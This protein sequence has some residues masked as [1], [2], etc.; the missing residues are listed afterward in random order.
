LNGNTLLCQQS[1]E[2]YP[3]ISQTQ[4][5]VY[6]QLPVNTFGSQSHVPLNQTL[7]P[8]QSGTLVYTR[9]NSSFVPYNQS[10]V[11]SGNNALTVVTNGNQAISQPANRQIVLQPEN[12]QVI[13]QPAN[14]QTISQPAI[15]QTI[16][17]PT[18]QQ[19]QVAANGHSSFPVDN[20][21]QHS[22]NSAF[23]TVSKPDENSAFNSPNV[24]TPASKHR[25]SQ[26]TVVYPGC[27]NFVKQRVPLSKGSHPGVTETVTSVPKIIRAPGRLKCQTSSASSTRQLT[28]PTLGRDTSGTST[29]ALTVN[30]TTGPKSNETPPHVVSSV[31]QQSVNCVSQGS[32]K[33]IQVHTISDPSM[34]FKLLEQTSGVETQNPTG[35]TKSSLTSTTFIGDSGNTRTNSVITSD[36]G[37]I[38][39]PENSLPVIQVSNI[40]TNT[41]NGLNQSSNPP[42]YTYIFNPSVPPLHPVTVDVNHQMEPLP[43][44]APSFDSNATP[45]A[46]GTVDCIQPSSLGLATTSPQNSQLVA[47]DPNLLIRLCQQAF[48]FQALDSFKGKAKKSL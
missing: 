13:N 15:R 44:A 47:I 48:S 26:I 22:S 45:T 41:I 25:P 29:A 28:G 8:N 21:N 3:A 38:V 39:V 31:N 6:V 10:S 36:Q 24:A 46:A 9:D 19:S 30:S 5:P 7:T 2:Q 16:G 12:Q 14:K 35:N 11:N 23:V 4:Q 32:D 1:T 40:Q 27:N 17:Q 43:A 33:L 18:N 42:S 20:R 37:S 34:L